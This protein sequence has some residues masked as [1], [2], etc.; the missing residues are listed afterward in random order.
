MDPEVLILWCGLSILTNWLGL[1][2]FLLRRLYG[3]R[4]W[5]LAVV[6]GCWV[7]WFSFRTLWTGQARVSGISSSSHWTSN[8]LVSSETWLSIVALSSSKS[9]RP[10]LKNSFIR[11]LKWW[12][13][14][15]RRP[16]GTGRSSIEDFS[17]VSSGS[18]WS[19]RSGLST[20]SRRSGWASSVI[21]SSS[22]W[23]SCLA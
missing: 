8:A 15:S 20:N 2:F 13:N 14:L 23:I 16:G 21:F 4:G 18:F 22:S 12:A 17:P 19:W 10:H 6:T 3:G 1:G 11:P 9:A 7:S 5:L